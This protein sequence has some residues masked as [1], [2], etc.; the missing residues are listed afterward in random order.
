[1]TGRVNWKLDAFSAPALGILNH[2]TFAVLG[3][4]LP[5]FAETF[6][7]WIGLWLFN[8]TAADKLAPLCCGFLCST[9]CC[10]KGFAFRGIGAEGDGVVEEDRGCEVLVLGME[11]NVVGFDIGVATDDEAAPC[12]AC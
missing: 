5:G 2:L 7:F 6:S 8:S 12:D 3:F 10:N 4:A 11:D 9:L 1:M